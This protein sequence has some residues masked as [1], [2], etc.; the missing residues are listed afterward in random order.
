MKGLNTMK[1]IHFENLSEALRE[2][3]Q[4]A[5]KELDRVE[6]MRDDVAEACA[7]ADKAEDWDACD[8]YDAEYKRRK[9]NIADLEA[10]I[11]ALH[12]AANA[13]EGLEVDGQDVLRNMGLV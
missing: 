4:A 13:F 1:A 6:E 2:L 7:A 11:R 5:E 3:M 12:D 8:K 9:Y 10:A